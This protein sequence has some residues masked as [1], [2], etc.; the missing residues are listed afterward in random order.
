[1][2]LIAEIHIYVGFF[3][4]LLEPDDEKLACPDLLGDRSIKIYLSQ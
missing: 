4:L 1:M 3:Q 2:S